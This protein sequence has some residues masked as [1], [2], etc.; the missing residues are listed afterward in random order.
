MVQPVDLV[1]V[2][3]KWTTEPFD[4]EK[5]EKS[6]AEALEEFDKVFDK[7]ESSDV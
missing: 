5:Y 3:A 6:K 2:I 1:E 7:K 4:Q